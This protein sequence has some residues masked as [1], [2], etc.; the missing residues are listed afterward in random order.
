MPAPVQTRPMPDTPPGP[1]I[2]A[3]GGKTIEGQPI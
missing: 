3:R 2:I 1:G